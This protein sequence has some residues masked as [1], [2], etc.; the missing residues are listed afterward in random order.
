MAGY[1]TRHLP[2]TPALLISV[3]LHRWRIWRRCHNQAAL[4]AGAL[5]E[6]SPACSLDL[7]ALERVKAAP[8]LKGLSR[9]QRARA[10]QGAFRAP[11][12]AR[13]AGRSVVLADNVYTS[14]ATAGACAL[15]LRRAGAARV[16]ILCWAR[17]LDE[18]ERAGAE[19]G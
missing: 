12:K 9:G 8:S 18:E 2:E 3:P 10:M 5:A 19:H 13:V 17:V 7:S 1:I 6:A 11:D 4:I 16:D 14:G 15:V